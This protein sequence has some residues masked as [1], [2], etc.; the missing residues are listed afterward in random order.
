MAALFPPLPG[1]RQL[2]DPA[3][4]G[5]LESALEALCH[6]DALRQRIAD[7]S[8]RTIG[9]LGLT[10]RGNAARVVRLAAALKSGGTAPARFTESTRQP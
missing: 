1:A 8:A 10:W 3:V 6:D 4:A 2:F 5:G 7:G 9:R